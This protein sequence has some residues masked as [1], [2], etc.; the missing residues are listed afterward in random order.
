NAGNS[1][2][3]I[4]YGTAASPAKMMAVAN[5][6]AQ[7]I[8]FGASGTLQIGNRLNGRARGVAGWLDEFCFYTGTGDANFVESVRQS[9]CPIVISGLTPDGTTLMQGTNTLSF[10]ASSVNTI[11]TNAIKVS[12]NGTD[13]SSNLVFGGSPTA[14]TVS[15]SG[16]PVNPTLVNNSS[17]NGT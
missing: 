14:V 5:V 17:L 4:Y 12:L 7:T 2:A 3:I 11:N 1:N 15:Y 13:I 10:T 6:G 9:S 16:L 8:N